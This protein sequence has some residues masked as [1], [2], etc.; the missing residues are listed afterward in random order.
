MRRQGGHAQH[1]GQPTPE[2]PPGSSEAGAGR[3]AHAL[4]SLTL[5]APT[6]LDRYRP[7][8]AEVPS[9]FKPNW[10]REG[11]RKTDMYMS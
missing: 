1:L 6:E 10:V 9:R 8:P 11:P 2:H 5:P 7:G 4:R 3:W